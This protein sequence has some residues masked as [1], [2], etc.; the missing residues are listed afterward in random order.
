MDV[1]NI[2]GLTS[3]M[4]VSYV[5]TNLD[6][7]LLLVL[8]LGAHPRNRLATLAGHLTAACGVLFLCLLAAFAGTIIAPLHCWPRQENVRWRKRFA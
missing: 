4:T 5:A 3:L 1:T 8:L 2:L 6:N 7:L